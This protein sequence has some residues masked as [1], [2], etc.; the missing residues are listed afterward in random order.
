MYRPD[1][2]GYTY[3]CE[4]KYTRELDRLKQRL[5]EVNIILREIEE[6]KNTIERYHKNMPRL[7]NTAKKP[8]LST[9]N[10]V[11]TQHLA[12]NSVYAGNDNLLFLISMNHNHHKKDILLTDR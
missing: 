7:Q 4:H 5:D 6:D 10:A 9:D 1:F 3:Y 8:R 12:R 2:S 11:S